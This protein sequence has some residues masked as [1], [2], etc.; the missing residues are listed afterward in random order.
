MRYKLIGYDLNVI[1]SFKKV[2][3]L[4]SILRLETPMRLYCMHG[5][6]QVIYQNNKYA[7]GPDV[8]KFL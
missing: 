1:S 3:W 6:Y 5:N 8:T 4:R 2:K 7:D